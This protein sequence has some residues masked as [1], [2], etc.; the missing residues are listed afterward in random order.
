MTGTKKKKI[1][2]ER[3]PVTDYAAEGKVLSRI[4]GKVVFI[5]GGAVPGDVVDVRLFK[6]KKDWAEGRAVHFHDHSP[7]R[8]IPFCT[9]FGV[10][11]G[12]KW[13]MLPYEKQLFYKQR[14]VADALQHIGKLELPEVQ[15]I[16]GAEQ[17][18]F[19]RNKL[20]FTFSNRA[21]L[22]ENEIDRYGW[23]QKNALGFHIPKMFDKILDIQTCYLQ[24]EP[25]NRIRN[26]I[27]DFALE[28]KYEFYDHRQHTGWLRNLIIRTT[29][30]GEVM[31]NLCIHHEDEQARKALL[32][33]LLNEI[34]EITTLLYT[35][36]SKKNDSIADLEP[37]AYYG[38]GYIYE[39]LENLLFKIGPKSFFQTN[40]LQA[41]VLYKVVK[42]FAGLT[43]RETIY[44]LYCGTGSIGIFISPNAKRVIGVELV[45]ESVHHAKENA[46][47]NDI[48]NITFYEGDAMKMCDDDFF[49]KN[50]KPDIVITDP[51]RA[52]MHPKLVEKLL[53]IAAPKIV[54]VSCNPATQARDLLKLSEKYVVKAIQP[55]DLFPHTH[56]IENV[57]LLE[58]DK[59]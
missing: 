12:C 45:A 4:D 3:L 20:E 50:G 51:P 56:H 28:K 21:F 29:T 48:N 31:I 43:G 19:Y 53:E 11:G 16:L 57:V 46:K 35:L 26:V 17:T 30:T 47:I 58:Q 1:L 55:V 2:L 40:T 18:Q 44:D 13:Q 23:Y 10:C 8:V 39:K 49:I 38:P 54:Y 25:S 52:G 27:R 41:E 37:V 36:N 59:R 42:D 5:E 34:P 15:P 24:A 6:N 9:H 32:D 7:E 33:H 14:Q 22:S